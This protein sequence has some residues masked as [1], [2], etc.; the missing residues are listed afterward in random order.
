[1]SR[2]NNATFQWLNELADHGIIITDKQFIIQSWNRWLE[3]H[4]GL[5]ASDVCGCNLLEL[6]PEIT[7]RHL[8][9]RYH[10]AVQGQV[11]VLAQR[12]HRYLLPFPLK[13]P[14]LGM[15]TMQQ[16]VRIA[17]LKDQD[18][19][20]GT[21][22]LIDDVTERVSREDELKHQ[23]DE[24]KE[25]Q[26]II[27]NSEA[28]YRVLAEQSLVGVY[29][30]A[31]QRIRYANAALAQIFGYQPAALIALPSVSPL[32]DPGDWAMLSARLHQ[33]LGPDAAPLHVRFR[34]RHRD[35]SLRWIEIFG[36]R[37]IYDGQPAIL[38]TLL[39]ITEQTYIEERQLLLA[40]ASALLA[41]PLH[42][43][44]M[45]TQ[46]AEALV[47]RL[48]D[49]CSIELGSEIPLRRVG[50]AVSSLDQPAA[51]DLRQLAPQALPTVASHV[52]ATGMQYR[53]SNSSA[54]MLF[55]AADG[56]EPAPVLQH[57]PIEQALFLPLMVHG[58]RFGMLTLATLPGHA[59]DHAF[60]HELL[61]ELA[62]RI[63]LAAENA[64]LFQQAQ[65]AL[66][67]RDQ[68]LSIA[69]H[70]LRTPMTSLLGYAQIL[71][72][73]L[74]SS[75]ALAER[76]QRGLVTIAAQANRLNDLIQSLFDIS[77][78]QTGQFTVHKIALDLVELVQRIV[79]ENKNAIDTHTLTYVGE[80]EKLFVNGDALRLEQ[81]VQN[82][83]QNA[84]KYSQKGSGVI[85]SV[86]KRAH[87]VCVIV[88]DQGVG[89]PQQDLDHIFTQF[90]RAQHQP[91]QVTGLGIGLFVVQQLVG[92]HDGTIEVQSREG[93]GS[94]FT[95]C[96][97]MIAAQEDMGARN[98]DNQ[99][100]LDDVQ[101]FL[102]GA[103]QD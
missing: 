20:I 42:N 10:Q 100:A 28:R 63:A 9:G 40:E 92:L 83:I 96:L 82:L 71:Q 37:A 85:V 4:S 15:Q 70:E 25:L 86:E 51:V 17:P 39:D 12:L 69:A 62:R 61:T 29:V 95:I 5:A 47:P 43:Q 2:I 26:Q 50:G 54:S 33:G 102:G 56:A 21:I 72:R 74:Q 88:K 35:G 27:Q 87:A 73:R 66:E 103:G 22:T 84:F 46:L 93:L 38:G 68:F 19:I 44:A 32:I 81:V 30:I 79:N 41:S 99:S 48:A 16:S 77:R 3:I 8:D 80:K 24:L 11:S 101:A 97:P 60:D 36:A 98:H 90:Y 34:G 31:D 67:I 52:L 45:F 64:Q 53:V 57:I 76:D 1:M 14:K 55:M 49:I 59:Y 7:T 23:I 18:E 65:Q 75:S 78:L 58:Q 89:I 6:F 91:E 94:T 13:S